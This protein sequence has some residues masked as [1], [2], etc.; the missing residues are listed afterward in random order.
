MLTLFKNAN[1]YAPSPLGTKDIL[2]GGSTILAI[3]SSITPP[4][5]ADTKEVDCTGLK[6]VPGFIDGHVHVTGGGGEGGPSTRMPELQVEMMIEG[7]VTTVV[8]CLGTDGITRSVESVLV[9]VKTLRA[10]G[11]SA[12]MYSGAYQVPPPTVTGDMKKD[13]AW[14]DEV[15]GIGEV[16]IADHRS[17]APTAAELARIAADCRV[18]G[19]L[20]G[21]AGIVN[22]H[23]GDARNPFQLIYDVVDQ[24][25]LGFK[26]FLPTHI[27]RNFH[28]FEDALTYGKEGFI[29]ITTS[30]WPYYP[31]E[32]VKPSIAL[33][34]LLD[35]GV[36]IGHITFTSDACG[37]L[38]AFDPETGKLAR[39]EMGL[40]SANLRELKDCVVDEG[41]PLETAL[42][43]LTSNP[44]AILKLPRK[45]N[46]I[47]GHDADL[48]LLDD[49]Y[50][51][52]NVMAM[53]KF[54]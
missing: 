34:R 41:I 35:A 4:S 21:K 25:E 46:L 18:A 23:M 32:E 19:M 26:D 17:S 42:Q 37:S 5:G 36:P 20:A 12:W 16:A 11:V 27:N 43:V 8:G 38:P 31:D 29:D 49:A 3:A 47:P 39:I 54:M 9:K 6:M 7:G 52:V 14:L 30:S 51:I 2:T 22:L 45:G 50:R 10:Q 13:I 53:G 40:P 44:A 48:V 1:V 33:K 15:I 24:T 28:I